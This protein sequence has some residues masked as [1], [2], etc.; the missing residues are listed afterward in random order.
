MLKQAGGRYK[1]ACL[2]CGNIF[3]SWKVRYFILHN[4][5][6]IYKDESGNVKEYLSYDYDFKMTYGKG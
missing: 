4:E 2:K 6:I 1:E 3:G 5:G